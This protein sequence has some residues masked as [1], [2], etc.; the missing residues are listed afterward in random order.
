MLP[1]SDEGR[2]GGLALITASFILLN[3]LVFFYEFF[4]GNGL[5]T[6]IRTSRAVPREIL[7][8]QDIAP[9]GPNPLYLQLL[10][11]MLIN[12]PDSTA[13]GCVQRVARPD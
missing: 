13:R 7:T 8:G 4:L 2:Q 9:A 10:T 5:A 11:A 6:I 3:I 12:G 1:T